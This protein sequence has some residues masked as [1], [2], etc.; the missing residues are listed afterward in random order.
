VALA[1]RAITIL[2][3]ALNTAS[4]VLALDSPAPFAEG[5]PRTGIGGPQP[6]L[7]STTAAT[8]DPSRFDSY[9]ARSACATNA[10]TESGCTVYA[11]PTLARRSTRPAPRSTH[12]ASARRIRSAMSRVPSSPDICG[13]TTKNSSPPNRPTRS[14][15]R[16]TDRSRFCRKGE[17]LV[18]GGVAEAVVDPLE[19]AE[20]HED[21]RNALTG[22]ARAIEVRRQNVKDR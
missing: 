9:I 19:A 7:A 13:Q 22:G 20:I 21:G 16:T 10:S 11:P 15:S 4:H 17:N 5:Q 14:P 3:T 6:S 2:P 1:W 12:P 8:D 18:S